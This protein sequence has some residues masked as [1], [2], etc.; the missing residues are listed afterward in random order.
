MQA[1]TRSRKGEEGRTPTLEACV[2]ASCGDR[3]HARLNQIGAVPFC[4]ACLERARPPEPDDEVGV[5]D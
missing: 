4:P 2:C 3:M 1:R 5:G